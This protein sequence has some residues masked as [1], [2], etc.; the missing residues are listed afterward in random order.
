[1]ARRLAP[2]LALVI[3]PLAVGLSS[4]ATPVP[5]CHTTD[6]RVYLSRFGAAA[7][8]VGGDV[9]GNHGHLTATALNRT[10]TPHG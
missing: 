1:M 8:T 9:A 4:A 7:G 5:R 3:L 10:R 2:V 6:L